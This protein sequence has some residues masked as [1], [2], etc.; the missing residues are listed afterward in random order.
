MCVNYLCS[1][2]FYLMMTPNVKIENF[3]L[4]PLFIGKLLKENRKQAYINI[5]Y[6]NWLLQLFSQDYELISHTTYVVFKVDS[7]RQIFLRSFPFQ[8]WFILSQQYLPKTSKRKSQIISRFEQDARDKIQ[9][10]R[11]QQLHAQKSF[12]FIIKTSIFLNSM[13]I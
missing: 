7:E 2:I 8:I 11:L 3:F 4:A 1:G 10:D 6:V 12:N 9:P 13:A 5:M